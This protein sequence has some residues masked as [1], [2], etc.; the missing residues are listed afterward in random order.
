MFVANVLELMIKSG[1]Y[2]LV[3]PLDL[4]DIVLVKR[5]DR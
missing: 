1:C 2:G 5:K 3:P 4:V